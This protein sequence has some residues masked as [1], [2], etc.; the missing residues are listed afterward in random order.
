MC[1]VTVTRDPPA[2]VAPSIVRDA[3]RIAGAARRGDG[4]EAGSELRGH[5]RAGLRRVA[6]L[7]VDRQRRRQSGRADSEERQGDDDL[8]E[9]ER[10]A[11]CSA[12]FIRHARNVPGGFSRSAT[13]QARDSAN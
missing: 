10:A 5:P 9:C 3:A 2:F 4:A 6:E 11:M 13:D 1:A 12:I 7:F 8:N